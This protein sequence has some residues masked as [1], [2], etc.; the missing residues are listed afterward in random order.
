[1]ARKPRID[2]AG[3]AVRVMAT[4]ASPVHPPSTVPLRADA[5]RFFAAIVAELGRS[6][7]S[8]H[9]LEIAALLARSMADFEREQRFLRAEGKV[10]TSERGAPA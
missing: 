5:R 7:W 4:A 9:T 10:L 8:A 3:E 6:E 1:M 2:S